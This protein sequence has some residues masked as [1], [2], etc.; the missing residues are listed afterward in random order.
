M[1]AMTMPFSV[2]DSKILD[3]LAANQPVTFYLVV[4]RSDA[5]IE[6][7]EPVHGVTPPRFPPSRRQTG[8][9]INSAVAEEQKEI[10]TW[11][12]V[13]I[14]FGAS[15]GFW[16][17]NMVNFGDGIAYFGILTL[18]TL[19]LGKERLGMSDHA[20]AI[21]VSAFTGLVTLTMFG[22]GFVSDKLGV[23]RALTFCL[24][25]CLAG[26]VLLSGSPHFGGAS[27]PRPGWGC[28]SFPSAR[29]SSS[30]RSTPGSRSTRTRAP[31]P[32]ATASSTPS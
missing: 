19:F 14:L 22:G 17:V 16:L 27:S 1:D 23:R 7:I 29:A 28:W 30:P 9:P 6:R 26:R 13:K 8:N 2:R 5:Y 10:G 12:S 21:S 4:T 24:L 11:E 18:L 20:A 15:K 3:G 25:L 31:P 32:W